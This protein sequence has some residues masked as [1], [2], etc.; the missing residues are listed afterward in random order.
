MMKVL[1]AMQV[2]SEKCVLFTYSLCA[3]S[4]FNT[5]SDQI[6]FYIIESWPFR[7]APLSTTSDGET[8]LHEGGNGLAKIENSTNK[9]L[10]TI[11]TIRSSS[12]QTY[13]QS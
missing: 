5:D 1:V 13:H 2:S 12:S 6:R 7:T 8:T 11:S 3:A 10:Q 9:T 4:E